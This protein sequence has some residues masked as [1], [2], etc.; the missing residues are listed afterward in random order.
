ML[1]DNTIAFLTGLTIGGFGT[2]ILIFLI[3][4]LSPQTNPQQKEEEDDGW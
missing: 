4:A 2:L 1:D 3:V